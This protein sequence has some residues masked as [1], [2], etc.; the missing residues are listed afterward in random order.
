M[1]EVAK[2]V[3]QWIVSNL[4]WSAIIVLFILSCLFKITKK[5]IDPLGWV[6]G[7]FGKALTK[8]VRKD[9]S[10]LKTETHEKFEEVK[11]DRASKIEELKSDYEKKISALREDLDSFEKRTDSGIDEMKAGTVENCER[12]KKR[13]DE[14]EA[15]HQK[16]ND[17]QT[18]MQI[19]AHVLDFANSC[20]NHRKHT[21]KDFENI[22]EEN[23]LYESLVEKYGLK[24]DIYKDD[25]S[26]ILEV[27]HKCRAEGNFLN[28]TP[29]EV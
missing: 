19:K 20:M 3:G 25:Y 7:W 2:A 23:T 13:M 24:N 21:K 17:M 16:S 1:S 15:A 26:Y 9:I 18:V 6:I 10:D 22:I 11:H 8:D 4:G 12:L 28:E 27:Y 29:V 5:E 14:M